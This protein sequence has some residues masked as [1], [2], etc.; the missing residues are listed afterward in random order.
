MRETYRRQDG[1]YFSAE[2]SS[3]FVDGRSVSVKGDLLG[4]CRVIRDPFLHSKRDCFVDLIPFCA[5]FPAVLQA[6]FV[7]PRLIDERVLKLVGVIS[8]LGYLDCDLAFFQGFLDRD[9]AFSLKVRLSEV[10]ESIRL[11][12]P[13][14][15]DS[16][17]FDLSG[18]IS[19][20]LRP[21][22]VGMEAE[23][24]KFGF[25]GE[26][27]LRSLWVEFAELY[28]ERLVSSN[29]NCRKNFWGRR[30]RAGEIVNKCAN[31]RSAQWAQGM[32]LYNR[33]LGLLFSPWGRIRLS[34]D[35][36]NGC[37]R[38]SDEY[39]QQI[40]NSFSCSAMDLSVDE[41]RSFVAHL[42]IQVNFFQRK[43]EFNC[44]IT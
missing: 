28:T 3:V 12:A 5:S 26:K 4:H 38:F 36:S 40:H 27:I 24:Q 34:P 22:T 13:F 9:G 42:D 25:L 10:R 7:D 43:Y 16:L 30:Q 44:A 6:Q 37:L 15:L 11:L 32:L 8:S 14:L 20:G 18:L 35:K 33:G 31:M 21:F 29:E 17:T 39:A 1:D 41:L 23:I 19:Q 2:F